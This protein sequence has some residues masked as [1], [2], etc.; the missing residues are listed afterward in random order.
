MSEIKFT[1]E[2]LAFM[3][4]ESMF[5]GSDGEWHFVTIEHLSEFALSL[6]DRAEKAESELN[7]ALL[8]LA[9]LWR[10]SGQAEFA[11]PEGDMRPPIVAKALAVRRAMERGKG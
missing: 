1:R 3:D 2:Q 4:E 5:E 7:E 6:L 10:A 9:E 8:E 11:N